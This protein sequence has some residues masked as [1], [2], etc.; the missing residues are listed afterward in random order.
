MSIPECT[1]QELR[2]VGSEKWT[3]ITASDGSPTIGAWVAE[4]DFGTAPA[5]AK[6]LH[7]AI[8]AGFTGYRPPWIED[9]LARATAAYQREHFGWALDARD[10]VLAEAVLPALRTTIAHLT[11]PGSAVVVPT[12]NYMPFLTIPGEYGREVIQVPA[13]HRPG[14]RGA[15][16]WSLDLDGVRAGLER[17]AGLVLL[18]NPW[19]PTGRV[20][21]PAELRAL[22]DVVADY[23]A[24]VFADEI[25]S[26]LVLDPG[27]RFTSY[28]SLGPDY[29]AQTVTAVAASKGWNIAGL[30]CAQVILPDA[31]LRERWEP[32]RA[33]TA[34]GATAFGALGAIA[35][36]TE[37]WAWLQEV[38]AYL[39]A[40]LDDLDRALAG[41]GIDYARP[42]ATFLT[43]WGCE[44]LRLDQSP[45][46]VLRERAHVATNP[47]A[48]LGA[49]Y[50]A[51]LRF[52]VA[53]PR[54]ILE[55][56]VSRSV[57]A[58]AGAR[59]RAERG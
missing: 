31:R 29:A 20:L 58:L 22:H 14:A 9:A 52:N 10:V 54:P 15:E 47:G 28:A 55:D 27:A 26:P 25:H 41:T 56:A 19:N 21:A 43:W 6:A 16:A 13:I 42:Q 23:D 53:T 32:F 34:H 30:P 24:L 44:G 45:A 40:N 4:M 18:C 59:A 48:A 36:Y 5:V 35:A 49:A 50:R 57:D 7:H 1:A 51:W 17:G 46:R 38:R 11:R 8:D 33:R 2:Q 12:P 39:R 3:G 37:G